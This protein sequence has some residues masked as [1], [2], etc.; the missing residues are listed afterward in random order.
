MRDTYIMYAVLIIGAFFLW[1]E[2]LK[3]SGTTVVSV[4]NNPANANALGTPTAAINASS[5]TP[6]QLGSGLFENASGL[7]TS[8]T[9]GALAQTY[10]NQI[11]LDVENATQGLDVIPASLSPLS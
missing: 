1:E 2:V 11:N 5:L 9:S 3:P 4:P 8:P 10:T 7:D 6:A